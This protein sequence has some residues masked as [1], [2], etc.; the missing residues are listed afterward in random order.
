MEE[1]GTIDMSGGCPECGSLWGDCPAYCGAPHPWG[2]PQGP[3]PAPPP[4]SER[5]SDETLR[6]ITGDSPLDPRDRPTPL[7]R[8]DVADICRELLAAREALDDL[9]A[10]VQVACSSL[11]ESANLSTRPGV[12]GLPEEVLW[13]EGAL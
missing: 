10:A 2:G 8:I 6:Y 3:K 1:D 9:R 4:T 7:P 5:V 12:R 13:L 11:R